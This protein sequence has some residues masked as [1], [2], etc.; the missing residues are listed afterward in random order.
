MQIGRLPGSSGFHDAIFN[1][2]SAFQ[3]LKLWDSLGECG[4]LVFTALRREFQDGWLGGLDF[5]INFAPTNPSEIFC[6]SLLL[7]HS[8]FISGV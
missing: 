3:L 2:I 8:Q 6:D 7:R 4:Q 1:M 5:E